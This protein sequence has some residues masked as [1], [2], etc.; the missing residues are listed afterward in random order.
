VRAAEG[1]IIDGTPVEGPPFVDTVANDPS[2]L[3]TCP[4]IEEVAPEDLPQEVEPSVGEQPLAAQSLLL[5][6]RVLVDHDAGPILLCMVGT[7]NVKIGEIGSVEG[8]LVAGRPCFPP[9]AYRGIFVGRPLYGD[10]D[11]EISSPVVEILP[12]KRGGYW[13]T[14]ETGSIYLVT[15]KKV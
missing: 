3:A 1:F 10:G 11:R 12:I 14:T 8:R 2:F 15:Q 5:I 7:Y 9:G 6:R 4:P 13:V